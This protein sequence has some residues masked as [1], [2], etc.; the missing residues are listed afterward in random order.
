MK[1]V[2]VIAS[3]GDTTDPAPVQAEY[4]FWRRFDIFPGVWKYRFRVGH[5]DYLIHDHKAETGRGLSP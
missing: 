2:R 3:D 5:T 4:T 1:N